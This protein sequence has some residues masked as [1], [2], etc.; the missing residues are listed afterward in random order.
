MGVILNPQYVVDN[1]HSTKAVMLS[2]E[3]WNQVLEAL[4]ELE[5]IRAYDA[6]KDESQETVLFEE[7]VRQI[8]GDDKE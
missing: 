1:E 2:I 6:A 7:A 8:Q 3:E 5:D 4:E